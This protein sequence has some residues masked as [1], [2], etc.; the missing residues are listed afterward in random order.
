MIEKVP[1]NL[2]FESTWGTKNGVE[3]DMCVR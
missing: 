3:N 1:K 2:F